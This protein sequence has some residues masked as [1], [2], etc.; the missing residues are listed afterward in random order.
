MLPNRRKIKLGK[1]VGFGEI[2]VRL[3]P[4]GYLKLLQADT[5]QVSYAGAEANV[6]VSLSRFGHKTDYITKLP[7]SEMSEAVVGALCRH[8]VGVDNIVYGGE[9][10]GLYYLERGASQRP[11]KVIYDRKYSAISEAKRDEFDWN[12]IFKDADWFHFSGITAALSPSMPDICE[13]ACKVAK[14]LGVKISC[15]LNYRAT[16][17]SRQDATRAMSHLARYVDVMIG[18]EEDADNCLGIRPENTDVTGGKLDYSAYEA[19]ARQIVERFGTT[20]VAFTLRGSVSASEN[21]WAA[22]LYQEGKAYYSKEYLIRLVD[23][24]GGGDSFSGGLIY[25]ML[26]EYDPQQAVEFAVAASCLKQTMEM[27]FNLAS[28]ADVRRLMDGDGSGR[29]QR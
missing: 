23:R 2:M 24:V 28:V 18:N 6:L 22:M 11:S 1:V 12:Y 7:C 27:D 4:P 21:K 9:R 15:D 3:Q 19:V 20:S 29:V 17:W 8:R 5:F 16:L 13:D 26:E 25:A 14:A 10:L